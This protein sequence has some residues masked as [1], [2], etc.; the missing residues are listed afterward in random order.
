MYGADCA[1]GRRVG[2][3]NGMENE[4]HLFAEGEA[5]YW[6]LNITDRTGVFTVFSGAVGLY[7]FDTV[8]P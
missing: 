6:G 7:T 3:R 4:N 2:D 5:E 8:Y 1:A